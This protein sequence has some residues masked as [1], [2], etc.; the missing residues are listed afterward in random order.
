M[1]K[2]NNGKKKRKFNFVRSRD[3]TTNQLLGSD[4]HGVDSTNKQL[5]KSG[6]DTTW[7]RGDD[8]T[9]WSGDDTTAPQDEDDAFDDA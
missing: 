7:R 5:L 1:R 2:F 4:V 9:W 3:P 6:D 8:T